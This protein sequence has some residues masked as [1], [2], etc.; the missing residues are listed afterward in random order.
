M[1]KARLSILAG[2]ITVFVAT[3][4]AYWPGLGGP[5]LFDDFG[6]ISRLGDLG[7]VRDWE[8]FKAFVF[9]GTAGPTGRPLAL[10]TFLIDARDWPADSWGF[11]R[12]NLV[13]HILNGAVLG[14]LARQVLEVLGFRKDKASLIA[15]FTAGCWLLH[16]F[17][18]ST[19]LYAVQRMAQL[20][21][22]FVFAGLSG[23]V[24]GRRQ[25]ATNTMRAYAIMSLSLGMFTVLAMVSK[26]NG[27]LLPVLAGVVEVTVF[28]GQRTKSKPLSRAWLMTFLVAP[29][30]VIFLYLARRALAA[31]FFEIVPPRDFSIYERV[32]T[33]P[34]VL[35]DYL[36]NWFVPKLYTTG[37]FQDHFIKSTSLFAP[38]T[39]IL[40]FLCHAALISVAVAVRTRRPL[41]ALAILFFYAGHL[42][43]ST[44]INLELYF[45]HRNYLSAAFLFLPLIAWLAKKV[46]TRQFLVIGIL[47]LSL[48]GGFTRYSATVW[49]DY[50]AMIATSAR[51]VPTSVR[52]QA[53]YSAMLFNAGYVDESF[54]VLDTTISRFDTPKPLLLV[55][56]LILSC[57]TERLSVDEFRRDT[58]TLSGVAYDAR[59]LKI[60]TAL[61]EAIVEGHCPNV[62]SDGLISMFEGMLKISP[63]D[64]PGTLGFSQ[65][66]Y[67]LGF[68]WA[69]AN[70]PADAVRAFETA[71]E[72]RPGA[73]AAMRMAMLLASNDYNAE[74][75]HLSELALQQRE[76]PEAAPLLGTSV[77]VADIR[78][79]QSVVKADLEAQHDS[80]APDE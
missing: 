64:E 74:A 51:K 50:D 54:D 60:Y 6:S 24:Y 9:G 75:L 71:I 17:L 21:S 18:V 32:L 28:S 57:H 33:Q 59:M 7:G 67:F 10:L 40:G 26:E 45:E 13:I 47:A 80:G 8:T 16:P 72:S 42:L 19:T 22:L 1:S 46:S 36:Q 79:F 49:A 30:V 62:S 31:D 63:G 11:K 56:R 76:S 3:L 44:V 52:A 70:K 23:Y 61:T 25:L 39:T 66:H 12:T 35:L 29:V 73:S 34:R 58:G 2:W 65:L 27:I 15:L 41:V 43:E 48:L 69:Y 14:M 4:L 38:I 77:S 20:S 55:Q 53:E 68:V 78:E 5:F 37:V